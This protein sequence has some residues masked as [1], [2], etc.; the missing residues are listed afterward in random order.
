MKCVGWGGESNLALDKHPIQGGVVI[1]LVQRFMPWKPGQ[2]LAGWATWP[3]Y[4][5]NLPW[6]ISLLYSPPESFT[7]INTFVDL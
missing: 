6:F 5:P 2:A 3:E 4:G 7:Q 1:L